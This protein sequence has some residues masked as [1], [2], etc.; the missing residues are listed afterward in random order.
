MSAHLLIIPTPSQAELVW[1]AAPRDGSNNPTSGTWDNALCNWTPD[2]G[3]HNIPWVAGKNAKL[4]GATTLTISGTVDVGNLDMSSASDTITGGTIN[5]AAAVTIADGSTNDVI[6]SIIA[7]AATSITKTGT[8]TLTISSALSTFIGN[9]LITAGT[10][11]GATGTVNGSTGFAGPANFAAT[12]IQLS[13]GAVFDNGGAGSGA[14]DIPYGLTLNG[15]GINGSCWVNSGSGAA[16]GQIQTPNIA[17]SANATIGSVTGATGNMAMIAP[18]FGVTTIVLVTFK[19]T[20]I[21]SNT[22]TLIGTSITKTGVLTANDVTISGGKLSTATTAL[23]ASTIG[24]TLSNTAGVILECLIASAIGALSTSG[25]SSSVTMASGITL[26]VGNSNGVASTFYNLSGLGSLTVTGSANTFFY[27]NSYSGTTTFSVSGISRVGNTDTPFGTSA[28][29]VASSFTL[30]TNTDSAATRTWSNAITIN[31]GV[32]LSVD[33]GYFSIVLSGKISGPGNL[34]GA[35]SGSVS[36]THTGNDNTGTLT[37]GNMAG[38][39][40]SFASWAGAVSINVANFVIT[41]T[42]TSGNL[43]SASS[44]GTITINASVTWSVTKTTSSTV[45]NVL[46]GAGNF[47]LLGTATLTMGGVNTCSGTFRIGASNGS[48]SFSTYSAAA[49]FAS[50]GFLANGYIRFTQASA[51]TMSR[52]LVLADVVGTTASAAGSSVQAFQFQTVATT[53][54]ISGLISGGGATAILLLRCSSSA[55][56]STIIV[57]AT[58]NT[59]TALETLLYSGRFIISAGVANPFGS[60]TMVRL[61]LNA[62]ASGD[63]VFNETRTF[64]YNLNFYGSTSTINANGFTVT[65]SGVVSGGATASLVGTGKFIFTAANTVASILVGSSADITGSTP[66]LTVSSG[67]RLS[68]GSAQTGVVTALT[69]SAVGSILDVN[70][71]T[72]SSC[73][74]ISITTLTAAS[75][76]SVNVLGALNLG[77]YTLIACSGALPSTV[78]TLTTNNSG[79]T[80]TL[81]WTPGIGLELLVSV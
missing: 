51:V 73:S 34:S 29:V 39:I 21:G 7:G 19:L 32:T 37:S 10:L 69:M 55:D 59:Y 43:T 58:S 4:L 60:S 54:T 62:S 76:F 61:W 36:L 57:M 79:H 72:T 42:C 24:I 53:H 71:I 23:A 70:S 50:L 45:N 30:A 56:A 77:T 40:L 78:P 65:L 66:A 18:S 8:G 41:A 2:G 14:S 67:G 44:T 5:F 6:S 64:S 20:K 22:I 38:M 52:P 16:L 3:F 81:M 80:C 63:L 48:M 74:M 11:K 13:A 9:L 68:G 1:D 17:L 26:T 75:G 46:A 15:T 47:V 28:L 33:G 35:S 31:S 27:S 49:A 12:K 25:N